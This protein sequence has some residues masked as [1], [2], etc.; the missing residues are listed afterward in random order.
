MNKF[1][2]FLCLLLF[3]FLISCK[4]KSEDSPSPQYKSATPKQAYEK[5]WS[6][7]SINRVSANVP[8]IEAFELMMDVYIVEY[9]NDSSITGSYT[10]ANETTLVLNDFGT[11]SIVSIGENQFNFILSQ[12]GKA[13]V[14]INSSPM[15]VVSNSA[16]TIALCN[17]WKLLKLT[18]TD[19]TTRVDVFPS[20]EGENIHIVFSQYGTYLQRNTKPGD[21]DHIESGTWGWANADQSAYYI[22]GNTG[23]GFNITFLNN[24]S[25]VLF[26]WTE[27]IQGAGTRSTESEC[28]VQ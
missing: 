21:S 25:V 26:N 18:E 5:K 10:R 24:N 4:K 13:D 17:T 20:L 8:T 7:N 2:V 6:V 23:I 1:N 3:S 15:A 9:S 14:T 19:T 11:L 16:Q 12:A 27:F 22:N 28:E